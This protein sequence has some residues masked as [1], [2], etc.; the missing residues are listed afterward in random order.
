MTEKNVDFF[1][2]IEWENGVENLL[3]SWSDIASCYCWLY[4][5]SYRKYSQIN[6]SFSLPIIIF[7]TITGTLIMSLDSLLSKD[8][9][10]TGQVVLGS[11]NIFTGILSTLQNYFNPSKESE[12]SLNAS[13]QWGKFERNIK[14]Q[15]TLA[16]HN[17]KEVSQFLREC[18]SEY[19]SL[20]ENSPVIDEHSIKNFKKFFKDSD[21]VRPEILD[22]IEKTIINKSNKNYPVT[23]LLNL[24]NSENS[25]KPIMVELD[26]ED[27]YVEDLK[28]HP[29]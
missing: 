24:K 12:A 17:R 5:K 16:R 8:Q 19:E 25:N 28:I 26:L 23:D 11:V 27:E 9:I 22:K 3:S 4:D 14:I 10:H 15:L 1:T 7:S 21:I 13:K 2:D 20:L 29:N 6:F 18:R